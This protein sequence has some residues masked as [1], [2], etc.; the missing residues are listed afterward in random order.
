[1]TRIVLA[2]IAW[3]AWAGAALAAG[4][5]DFALGMT[6]NLRG[7]SQNAVTAFTAALAAP[8]LAAAYKAPAYRGRAAAYLQLDRCQEA[9]DDLK[10]YELLKGRDETI[11]RYRVETELCLKDTAAARKDLQEIAKGNVGADDLWQFARVE[12]RY[13]LFEDA[14]TAGQ[15]AFSA[16]NKKTRRAAYFLL[17]Q[18]LTAQRAGKFDAAN[19]SA[20]LAQLKLDD[21][22]K[23]LFDLY[24]GQQTPEGVQNEAK[25][26]HLSKQEAQACEANFYTAEW[27]LGRG[28][29]DA[30]VP[31]LLAVTK[32][33][34]IDF[35][36]LS[37]S[38]SELKRL[39]IAV[40]EE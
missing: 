19:I 15:E 37:A 23:P 27:H 12:W 13:G 10:A 36:E 4:Y 25:T 29:K 14:M 30:A 34:P 24:L 6:E 11:L 22:P 31:L 7:N 17:W 9:L 26:L 5:D 2:A 18:A 20:G 3:A 39:G 1:M 8:D 40:P 35:I 21:W 38:K 16:I 32:R 33:C 28:E